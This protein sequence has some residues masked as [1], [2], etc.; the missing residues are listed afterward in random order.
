MGIRQLGFEGA[1]A[2]VVVTEVP[3]QS[4]R[5]GGPTEEPQSPEDPSGAGTEEELTG[6]DAG[7]VPSSPAAGPALSATA[8]CSSAVVDRDELMVSRCRSV[9]GVARNGRAK[10]K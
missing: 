10:G 5:G 1:G 4:G 9:H 2:V 7:E 8:T 3:S 6:G